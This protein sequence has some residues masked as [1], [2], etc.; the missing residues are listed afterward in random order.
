M[1]AQKRKIGRK[2]GDRLLLNGWLDWGGFN[3]VLHLVPDVRRLVVLVERWLVNT[4]PITRGTN[5]ST[6]R[7]RS[8]RRNPF[9]RFKVEKM[10]MK[11][12][13]ELGEK[14]SLRN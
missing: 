12:K 14:E 3:L 6:L 5:M 1:K 2:R 11:K 9:N 4:S 7:R 8:T 13:R 10:R